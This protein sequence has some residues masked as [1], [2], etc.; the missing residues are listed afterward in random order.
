MRQRPNHPPPYQHG[1]HR[2][3][4]RVPQPAG[5]Q[6]YCP[7]VS[8][9]AMYSKR[10]PSAPL[11]RY[12]ELDTRLSRNEGECISPARRCDSSYIPSSGAGVPATQLGTTLARSDVAWSSA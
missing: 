6:L 8:W 11:Y 5:Q 3:P 10:F 12:P 7:A 4:T 9:F 2:Q 1:Y